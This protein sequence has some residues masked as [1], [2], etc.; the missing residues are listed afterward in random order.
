MKTPAA[1]KDLT[2]RHGLGQYTCRM[3]R[4][5]MTARGRRTGCGLGPCAPNLTME[6]SRWN[7]RFGDYSLKAQE[8]THISSAGL[9][10]ECSTR[11]STK[12]KVRAIISFGINEGKFRPGTFLRFL[13]RQRT[14]YTSKSS[15]VFENNGFQSMLGPFQAKVG[16]NGWFPGQAPTAA[17]AGWYR[18]T[19]L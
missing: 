15:E 16:I 19:S 10:G 7:W 12:M 13:G 9:S 2:P 17:K 11:V 4:V 14:Y 6:D 5:I 1:R 3:C 18:P 8:L